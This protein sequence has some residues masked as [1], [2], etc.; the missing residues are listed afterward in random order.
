MRCV[1]S[2]LMSFHIFKF[3]DLKLLFWFQ[4]AI[5][6]PA[7]DFLGYALPLGTGSNR[8]FLLMHHR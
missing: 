2:I 4:L 1:V 6:A 8:A 7:I 3:P 5:P